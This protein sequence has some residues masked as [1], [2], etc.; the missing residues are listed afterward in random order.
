MRLF[1]GQTRDMG[2]RELRDLLQPYDVSDIQIVCD[3]DGRSRGFAFAEVGDFQR[4]I[5]DL[6]RV[7][8]NQRTLHVALARERV[9]AA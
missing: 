6:N 2:E 4:A 1:I 8:W 9:H 3:R 7:Q 5:L